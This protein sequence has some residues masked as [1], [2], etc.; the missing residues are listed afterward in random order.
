MN[1]FEIELGKA[2]PSISKRWKYIFLHFTI[3][4]VQSE[5]IRQSDLKGG[6]C[7][8]CKESF[9]T[10]WRLCQ[11]LGKSKSELFVL[12]YVW[13]M[14]RMRTCSPMARVSDV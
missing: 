4:V 14:A 10:I 12:M 6:R 9:I 11:F 3:I 7:K 1:G 8:G 5:H 13:P 2:E